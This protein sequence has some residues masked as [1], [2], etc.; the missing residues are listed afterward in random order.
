MTLNKQ[1]LPHH[2]LPGEDLKNLSHGRNRFISY[3]AVITSY[4]YAHL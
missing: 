4:H 3:T 2:H 1:L